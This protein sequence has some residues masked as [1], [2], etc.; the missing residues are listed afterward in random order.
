MWF[1]FLIHVIDKKLSQ[2]NK[3]QTQTRNKSKAKNETKQNKTN[4]NTTKQKQTKNF[5]KMKKKNKQTKNKNKKQT[6]KKKKKDFPLNPMTSY[7]HDT[8]HMYI[9]LHQTD[10][11]TLVQVVT[12][13][14]ILKLNQFSFIQMQ[15]LHSI[16]SK[17]YKEKWLWLG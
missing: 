2:T 9:S 12:Y 16:Q 17:S 6:N 15:L 13:D 1:Y 7:C 3:K 10:R 11:T 14:C 4:K 5:K 8:C